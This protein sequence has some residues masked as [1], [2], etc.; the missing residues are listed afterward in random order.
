MAWAMTFLPLVFRLLGAFRPIVR[1]GNTVVVTRYD[2]VRAVLLD[3]QTMK[4]HPIV[5][6]L[7]AGLSH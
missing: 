3:D 1:F 7:E 5:T 2:D 6:P 4:S